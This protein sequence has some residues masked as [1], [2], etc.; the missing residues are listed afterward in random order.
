MYVSIA[1]HCRSSNWIKCTNVEN[2]RCYVSDVLNFTRPSHVINL[3]VN[4]SNPF[5]DVTSLPNTSVRLHD[6]SK[7]IAL[8]CTAVFF[9]SVFLSFLKFLDSHFTHSLV[10]LHIH[11]HISCIALVLH[12]HF[13]LGSSHLILLF[14]TL[15]HWIAYNVLTC[16]QETAHYSFT[17]CLSLCHVS[18]MADHQAI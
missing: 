9:L 14:P 5:G 12:F 10:V 15:W 11:L 2:H 7:Y 16:Y 1:L 8:L 3:K 4:A 17:Y 6:V 18:F 13:I